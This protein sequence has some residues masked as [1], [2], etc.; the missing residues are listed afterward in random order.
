MRKKQTIN[1]TSVSTSHAEKL[2][3]AKS[4]PQHRE[5]GF[6]GMQN[7]SRKHRRHVTLLYQVVHMHSRVQAFWIVKMLEYCLPPFIFQY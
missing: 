7:I 3:K 1:T 5:E 6:R 2:S 4:V